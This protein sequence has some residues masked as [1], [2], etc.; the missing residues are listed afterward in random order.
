MPDE[1]PKSVQPELRVEY[2]RG[3]LDAAFVSADP[4]DQFA[5]WFGEAVA[6]GIPEPNAMT[7]ATASAAGVPSARVVLLKDFDRRGFAFYTNT[8]SRK[9]IDLA[10]NPRAALCFF[11]QP[12]ERQVRIEGPVEPVGRDE[13]EQYFRTRPREAQIGA[14]ASAQSQVI[15]SRMDLEEHVAQV[16]RR[17]GDDP[18]P[19][20]EFWGGYRVVPAVYEFWQ[21]RPSRLHDRIRYT[22]FDGRWR[23]ERLAP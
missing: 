23:I 13:A 16:G 6:A 22:R 21:G 5:L 20:P 14:W 7:L 3:R 2:T 19:L 11:W 17:F 4:L 9:G 12:L 1:A 8:A 10:A 18:I 15:E